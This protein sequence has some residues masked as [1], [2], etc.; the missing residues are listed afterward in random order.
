MASPDAELS[1]PDVVEPEL[2]PEPELPQ[3]ASIA[4][5]ANTAVHEASQFFLISAIAYASM[6]ERPHCLE[7]TSVVS[8]TAHRHCV[9]GEIRGECVRA[10]GRGLS[11]GGTSHLNLIAERTVAR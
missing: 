8:G 10:L 3:P 1:L 4:D 5:A 6:A 11:R 7:R 9:G 2:E